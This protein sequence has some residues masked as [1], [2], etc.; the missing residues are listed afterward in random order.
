MTQ[1]PIIPELFGT[2]SH[3]MLFVC[4]P[5]G[6]ISEVNTLA[7]RMLGN[8]LVGKSFVNLL[9]ESSRSKGMTLLENLR[10]YHLNDMSVTWELIFHGL[11]PNHLMVHVRAGVI[12]EDQWLIV[13]ACEPPQLTAIY[14]EVLAMNSELTNLIRQLSKDQARLSTHLNRLLQEKS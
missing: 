9:A 1:K 13:G 8:G 12:A 3:D 7:Q 14:Y 6:I 5:E 4:N 11:E 10:S 2:L